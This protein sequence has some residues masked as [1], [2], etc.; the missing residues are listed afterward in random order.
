M[1]RIIQALLVII[2]ISAGAQEPKTGCV[3]GNCVK[4]EGEYV[5]SNG[6]SYKG[7]FVNGLREG[8]GMLK[9]A[10][11]GWY[12]GMWAADEFEGQGTYQWPDGTKYSGAWKKGLQNGYG[13]YF[14]PNG[15]KYT[16]YFMDNRFE[17]EGKYTFADGTVQSGMFKNGELIQKE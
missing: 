5:Y 12:D 11:G 4:G 1:K 6:Y 13:I 17:G 10:D 16:G 3:Y 8:R 2:S 14:Y 15:D 7:N 9:A